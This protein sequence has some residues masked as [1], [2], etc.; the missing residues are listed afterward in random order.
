MLIMN[1]L[2]ITHQRPEAGGS[3]PFQLGTFPVHAKAS[4]MQGT[5]AR[6]K[7]ISYLMPPDF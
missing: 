6:A 2:T 5:Q 7:V 3:K 1:V 4:V